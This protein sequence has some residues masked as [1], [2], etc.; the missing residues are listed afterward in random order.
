[1]RKVFSRKDHDEAMILNKRPRKQET[2]PRTYDRKKKDNEQDGDEQK[3]KDT[4]Q[5]EGEDHYFCFC[6]IIN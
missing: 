5:N 2:Q 3:R 6:F 1:M 4:E